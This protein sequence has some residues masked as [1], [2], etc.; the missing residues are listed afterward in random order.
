M[1]NDRAYRKAYAAREESVKLSSEKRKRN[2][3]LPVFRDCEGELSRRVFI[4][5]TMRQAGAKILGK[6]VAH[7]F[8]FLIA[9]GLS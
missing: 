9:P 6:D 7:D 5:N 3:V 8:S 2:Y 1:Q 4:E